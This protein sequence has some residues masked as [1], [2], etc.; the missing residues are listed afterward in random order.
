MT[1][2]SGGTK[3]ITN[4]KDI[5]IVIVDIIR[6][7]QVASQ[8]FLMY[9]QGEPKTLAATLLKLQIELFFKLPGKP[10]G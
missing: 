6:E 9:A 1:S 3:I 10:E 8:K 4:I 7:L 2:V 5:N